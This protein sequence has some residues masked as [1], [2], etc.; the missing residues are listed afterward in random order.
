M[1]WRVHQGKLLAA[2]KIGERMS[3]LRVF[4]WQLSQSGQLT[5]IDNRGER[6]ISLP[7]RYDFEWTSAT[8]EQHVVGKHSHINI[9]DTLFG[10]M[11]VA[12]LAL[13]DCRLAEEEGRVAQ[14]TVQFLARAKQHL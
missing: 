14:R 8:R 9:L 4:R 5:Y 10:D 7:P 13:L 11:D 2:F 6:D 12:Q 3:D 1:Q